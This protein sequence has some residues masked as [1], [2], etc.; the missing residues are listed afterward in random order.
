MKYGSH[1]FG[2]LFWSHGIPSLRIGETQSNCK[3]L[4]CHYT[5]KEV[6]NDYT[7]VSSHFVMYRQSV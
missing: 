2:K 6:C 1:L 4:M 7:W 5:Y 3:H